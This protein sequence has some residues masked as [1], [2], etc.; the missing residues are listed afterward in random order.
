MAKPNKKSM[1]EIMEK[2]KEE[3]DSEITA[4]YVRLSRDDEL[5]GESNSISN[6]KA[7][8]T[9]YAKRHKFKNVRVFAD[10]GV[11]GVTMNRNGFQEMM[12]LV[13]AGKVSTV[14]VKDMSRLGRNYLEVGQL[15]ETIFPMHNVHFIAVN[16]GVDSDR[17]ED[18]FTPFR[19]IMNEWY[20]KDMSRKMRSSMRTKSKQGYAIGRPPLGYMHDAENPKLWAI[21]PEG[22]EII[23][24]IYALRMDGTSVNEIAKRLRYEKV[25]I[26]SIYAERKGFKKPTRRASRGEYQWDTSMVRQI[27]RNQEYVGD[28]LNFRTYSKSY[29]LKERLE[30]PRENWEIHKDVHEPIISREDWEDVQK[31]FG[32]T[33]YRKPKHIEKNMFCGYLKCSDCGANLNYKYTHDNPDNHYFSCRNKRAG[34]GLCSKTHHIRVD[35]ITELVRRNLSEI[36]RFAAAFEDEFVKIVMDEQYKQIQIQQR[37]NQE[38]LQTLLARNREVDVLYEKLF[39]EKI[40]GNLT[41]DRFK[42]L[43]EKYEDEQAE[44]T[45][46]I[47][48][49]KKVVAEEQKHELNA[50]GFLQLVRKYTDIQELTPEILR[51]FIDKIVVHHREKQGKETVQQVDIYYRFIGH[52]ELPKLSKP[53]REA[54]LLSFGREKEES[55]SA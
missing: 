25:L 55:Q 54:Y 16:D 1:A 47:R 35:V 23:R 49:M 8:L 12:A 18:D 28:V 14:I 34:N 38:T 10:D 29:K 26:P 51:E 31:T 53:Q 3:F 21:D 2:V 20:A 22:A 11:S 37:K 45:Q 9:D 24:H 44:L 30:N 48:H 15:T 27:L 36:V 32:D 39:E 52:V 17:G 19:N 41:E 7:L 43:S 6:Q 42:K 33:K 46:R 4:L 50:E 40:L 13:E 5:E